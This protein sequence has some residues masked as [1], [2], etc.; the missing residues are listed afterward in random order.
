MIY[1][2]SILILLTGV[3]FFM[4]VKKIYLSEATDEL[5]KA[6]IKKYI[7]LESQAQGVD[8]ALIKAIIQMESERYAF[9]FR[10]EPQLKHQ[11]WYLK[12]LSP[13]EKKDDYSY[14]SYGLMQVLF[15]IAK[16]LGYKGSPLNLHKPAFSIH[17]GVKLLKQLLKRYHGEIKDVIAAYNQG[18][19]KKD[20]NGQYYNQPYVNTVYRYYQE[21]KASGHP[22]LLTQIEADDV[23]NRN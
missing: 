17:Y 3:F 12:L 7:R 13:E 18:S 1:R 4:T 22:S 19:N 9:A 8:K 5:L 11:S 20:K 14:C 23:M 21:Y 6:D 10:Y 2:K 15:G 16:S